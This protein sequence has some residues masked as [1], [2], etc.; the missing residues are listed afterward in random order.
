MNVTAKPIVALEALHAV[1]PHHAERIVAHTSAGK[2][3]SIAKVG[4]P[5]P[6]PS[7][8]GTFFTGVTVG[9]NVVF[10]SAARFG[11]QSVQVL[12]GSAAHLSVHEGDPSVSL[13]PVAPSEWGVAEMTAAK[14]AALAEAET[15]K[16]KAVALA[17]G[18]GTY[19]PI[20]T[21]AAVAALVEVGEL[22]HFAFAVGVLIGYA[23]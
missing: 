20:D 13:T 14:R 4:S 8:L 16:E 2:V 9:A 11:S 7:S 5:H 10:T 23:K 22:K 19:S 3:G 12:D 17:S 18:Y 6:K 15:L 21:E 1:H